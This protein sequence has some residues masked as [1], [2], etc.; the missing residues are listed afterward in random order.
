VHKSQGLTFSRAVV[1]LTGGVFAGGQ[2]YVALSRC[3]SLDGL[4][5]RSK[6]T[7]RDIFVRREIVQFSQQFNNPALIEKSLQ[8]GKAEM[9][10][11]KAAQYFDQ[12][13]MS[14]A[15]EAFSS[16]LRKRNELENPKVR[17]LVSMKLEHLNHEVATQKEK[18]KSLEWLQNNL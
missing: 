16:A 17:R 10:Y 14:D 18:I 3:T 11:Q 4:V 8:E 12:R 13:K 15:V 2:T 7:Q 6:V 1:D 9:L 5:L